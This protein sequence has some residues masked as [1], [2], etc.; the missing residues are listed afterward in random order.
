V[1]EQENI[2]DSLIQA[3]SQR[4]NEQKQHT[5]SLPVPYHR[6]DSLPSVYRPG[7]FERIFDPSAAMKEDFEQQQLQIILD[8]RLKAM[9]HQANAYDET[10]RLDEESRVCQHEQECREQEDV[11]ERFSKARAEIKRHTIQQ[12]LI[13]EIADLH[14]D[15]IEE[16][17]LISKIVRIMMTPNGKESQNG[18]K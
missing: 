2:L 16:Q 15:P 17:L 10:I 11:Q 13:A 1:S 7:F 8:A 6:A 12:S 18:T 9:G 14:L 3:L 4:R 5:E